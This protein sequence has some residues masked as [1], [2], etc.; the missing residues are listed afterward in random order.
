METVAYRSNGAVAL[1]GKSPVGA[2]AKRYSQF[3][4]DEEKWEAV[5]GNL[6][7]ATCRWQ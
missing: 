7:F 3:S 2:T 6:A 5:R 1:N 4:L